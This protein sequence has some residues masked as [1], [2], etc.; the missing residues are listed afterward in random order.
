MEELPRAYCADRSRRM[1]AE[2]SQDLLLPHP[3][4]WRHRHLFIELHLVY[5]STMSSRAT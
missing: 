5:L 3:P 2:T 4:G 1:I